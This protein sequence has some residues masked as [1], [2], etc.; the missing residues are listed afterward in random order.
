MLGTVPRDGDPATN[1]TKIW[2]PHCFEELPED[3]R[4]LAT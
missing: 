1:V 4:A 2:F 3:T